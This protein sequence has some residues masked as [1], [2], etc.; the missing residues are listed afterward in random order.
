[1]SVIEAVAADLEE[2]SSVTVTVW[3][4]PQSLVVVVAS[5]AFDVTVWVSVSTVTPVETKTD[6]E[7]TYV[8]REELV[9]EPAVVEVGAGAEAVMEEVPLLAVFAFNSKASAPTTTTSAMTPK[10]RFCFVDS[11]ECGLLKWLSPGYISS[12]AW[13]PKSPSAS[14]RMT[15]NPSIIASLASL[16]LASGSLLTWTAS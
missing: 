4:A 5:G 16:R 6:P 3:V 9:V 1:M 14:L 2:T 7:T 10:T 13:I 15:L 8:V 12:S 11:K